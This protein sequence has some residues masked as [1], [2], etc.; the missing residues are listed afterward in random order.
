M[1]T[2]QSS[3]RERNWLWESGLNDLRYNPILGIGKGKYHV[4]IHTRAHSNFV[5]NFTEVGL[6]GF[7]FWL[8][9]SYLAFKGLNTVK[10][11]FAKRKD[12]ESS[13]Y[14]SNKS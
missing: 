14:I 11:A 1:D 9:M 13:S 2:K 10:L 8:G 6:V 7:F 5:Q 3:A 12:D 4:G